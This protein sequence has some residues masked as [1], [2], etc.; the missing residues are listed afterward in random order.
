MY[1]VQQNEHKS[2]RAI[3]SMYCGER[4]IGALTNI[5]GTD[6]VHYKWLLVVVDNFSKFVWAV[7]LRSKECEPIAGAFFNIISSIKFDGRAAVTVGILHTDNGS[8]FVN[9]VVAGVAKLTS[10]N[11]I[12]GAP[13]TPTSQGIVEKKN[14]TLKKKILKLCTTVGDISQW[15][16]QLPHIVANENNAVHSVTKIRP[17]LLLRGYDHESYDGGDRVQRD[18]P[19]SELDHNKLRTQA[20]TAIPRKADASIVASAQRSTTFL[21]LIHI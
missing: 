7:P 17:H 20:A 10:T 19:L 9:S 13:Y 2:S 12:Q 1:A 15:H 14:D 11:Q 16:L 4:L 21:S 8:E 3:V 5:P 6:D 18:F